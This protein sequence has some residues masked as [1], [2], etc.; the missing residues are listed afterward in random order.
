MLGN[1]ADEA[2]GTLTTSDR[3]YHVCRFKADF[4]E[5]V[6]IKKHQAEMQAEKLKLAFY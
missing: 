6:R 4:V 1:E 5:V 2:A 3:V